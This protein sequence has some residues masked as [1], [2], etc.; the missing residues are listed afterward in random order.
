[1][2]NL[3]NQR[4]RLSLVHALVEKTLNS[5]S[6]KVILQHCSENCRGQ[7]R[8]FAKQM[9]LATLLFS[10]VAQTNLW[11]ATSAYW[12]HEEGVSGQVIPEGPDTVLDSS[13]NGNHMQTFSS[14][15]E[16]PTAATYSSNVS[17]LALRSGLANTLSLDFGPN[18]ANG[19]EDG[20]GL[21]D[22][23]FT[24]GKLIQTE[25]FTAMTIEFAFNMNSIGGF[26]AL[27]GKDG[28]PLGDDEGE[29]DS[30]VPPLKIM[31]RGDNFPEEVDNQLFI[32][33]ID[34]DGDV[35]FLA[36]GE[37]VVVG[38]WNHFAFTLTDSAAELW[39]TGETGDYV[40]K[41]AISGEDFAGSLGPGEVIIFDPTPF[42]LGRGMFDNGVADWSD[43]LIDEV[44][45]SNSA[46]L[47]N[48]FLFETVEMTENANFDGDQD[49]DGAD[50]L[51]WQR[52]FGIDDGS[53]EL[54][55]GDA[56]GDGNVLSEDLAIWEN[57]YSNA[58]LS[59]ATVVPEPTGL[60]L[61]LGSLFIGSVIRRKR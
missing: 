51:I 42:T 43:A 39:M 2:K 41:D 38:E 16:A 13:S 52:G 26:Q 18:P 24:A 21:N 10:L 31:I 6:G 55:D 25:L 7:L 53:A 33:W 34:G 17:P 59:A 36:S 23:N 44:R 15:G 49:I 4:G 1:M 12:R 20:G 5:V 35:H 47:P 40:L 22:D 27:L 37:T 29:P 9:V 57:Q 58:V 19:T 50:F 28:K 32:E 30:P 54:S 45:I 56:N 8:L 14:T 11:G 48:E 46:L 60:V 3:S 61:M